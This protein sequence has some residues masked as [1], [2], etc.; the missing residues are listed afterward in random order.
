MTGRLTSDLSALEKFRL[1]ASHCF[2][3]HILYSNWRE[4]QDP[5]K[6]PVADTVPQDPRSIRDFPLLFVKSFEFS[7]PTVECELTPEF[8]F[9]IPLTA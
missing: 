1:P 7:Y 6:P 9:A 2:I 8:V 3:R 4:K 5:T